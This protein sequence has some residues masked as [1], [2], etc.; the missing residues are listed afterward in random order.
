MRGAKYY[1]EVLDEYKV[2][3]L[4]EVILSHLSELCV[5]S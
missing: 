5:T 1:F 4:W 3:S 2:I